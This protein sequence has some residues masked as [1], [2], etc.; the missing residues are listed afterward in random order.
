[1]TALSPFRLHRPQRL[2]DALAV[3]RDLAS[4]CRVLAGGTDLVV[5]LRHGLETPSNVLALARLDELRGIELDSRGE[6]RI[7]ALATIGTISRDARIASRFPVLSRA[8]ASISGPTLRAMGTLGGNLCLD[9]RCHWYNQ[10]WEWRRACGFC[11][12]K[13]GDICHV[14]RSSPVC[15]ATSS[16]DLA[17]ALLT[18]DAIVV[19]ASARDGKRELPLADFYVEDGTRKFDLREDELLTAVRVPA[20]SAGQVG[21]YGKVRVRGAI[22]YALAGVAVAGRLACD[23]TFERAAIAV[24][25]VGPRP[26]RLREAET[27]LVGHTADDETIRAAT[28]LVFRETTP[29]RTGGMYSPAYRRLRVRLLARDGLRAIAE[30]D[31][32]A[33]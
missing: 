27:L 33:T 21:F 25:A 18:L 2:D 13:D 14:A 15:V 24:T 16:G 9:T 3:L 32:A 29:L 28:E 12:K 23:H 17:P 4:A 20:A 7:G 1:M 6:L 31:S 30:R 5:N 19:L 11:L 22:D 26:S 8:A 10:S